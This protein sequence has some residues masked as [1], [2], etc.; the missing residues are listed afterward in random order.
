M[1]LTAAS[2]DQPDS[3]EVKS[4]V[5]RFPGDNLPKGQ[6]HGT[7]W[8]DGKPVEHSSDSKHPADGYDEYKDKGWYWSDEKE[9]LKDPDS[10]KLNSVQERL[11]DLQARVVLLNH[12]GDM[13]FHDLS[14]FKEQAL[15][16]QK[17]LLLWLAPIHDFASTS[18]RILEALELAH[19]A[20]DKDIALKELH[21]ALEEI[22]QLIGESHM[23]LAQ[24][25]P[26]SLHGSKYIVS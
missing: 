24:H 16:H 10:L 14:V 21:K 25:L 7:E 2:A 15:D 1:G 5:V 20:I 4:F 26:A 12:Q 22:R 8:R 19:T 3:F 18:N 6:S 17:E 9:H 23:S 13:L 11:E